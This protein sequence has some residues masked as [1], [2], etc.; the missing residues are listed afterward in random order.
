MTF[1]FAVTAILF[2]VTINAPHTEAQTISGKLINGRGTTEK[3][4]HVRIALYSEKQ[5]IAGAYSDVDGLFQINFPTGISVDGIAPETFQL[6]QNYPNPFSPQTT[7][8]FLLAEGGDVTLDIFNVLGQH[9]IT[10]VDDFLSPGHHAIVWNGRAASDQ[11]CQS[12]LYFYRLKFSGIT[13]IRKMLYLG[14]TP[15]SPSSAQ[16][17]DR[18]PLLKTTTETFEVQIID[19]DIRDTTLTVHIDPSLEAYDLGAIKIHVYPFVR[20]PP[21]TLNLMCGESIA[22]TI[23]IFFERP[24]ELT[25][26]NASITWTF[27]PDSLVAIH[28]SEIN[29]SPVHIAIREIDDFMVSYLV[30]HFNLSPRLGV[31]KSRLRRGY[32]GLPYSDYVLAE[33]AVGLARFSLLS[34]MPNGLDY[35][36][37]KITGVPASL[38]EGS[39]YFELLDNRAIAVADSVYWII[40]EPIQIDMNGYSV[41]ILEEY[42]CDGTH[43]YAWLDTY[44]GVTRDLYYKNERIARANPDGSRSCYC[45]G[46]TFEDFFRAMLQLNSDLN[47][48]GDINGMTAADM[49]YF[50]HIWFVQSVW[51]DGPGIAL[52]QFGLGEN[53][54]QFKDVKTGDYVQLWRTTGSGHS[55]IFMNWTTNAAG[56]TTGLR[57]WSTQGSTNGINYAIEYFDGFGGTVNP[58][59]CYF[60][61]VHSPENFVPFSRHRLENYQAIALGEQPI[62]PKSFMKND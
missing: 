21:D 31:Q 27:T 58:A 55:V 5:F 12:G 3:L 49:R 56:D 35:E 25:S 33:N 6:N 59:L 30:A 24:I 52:Q 48:S 23:D 32:L 44:T 9:V 40:R 2:I 36:N 14:T 61:R 13:K 15:L 1:R 42:P 26:T 53:I 17:S 47:R 18:L 28:Y 11:E 22:D 39:I 54:A 7:I 43:P 37:Q 57:Y 4:D 38:F 62:V 34:P 10:L 19:R 8:S 20:I 45:C 16:Q 41:D 60:S 29:E 51:G 46:L 50:I